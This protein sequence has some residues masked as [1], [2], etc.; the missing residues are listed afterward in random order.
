MQFGR[1]QSQKYIWTPTHQLHCF[2]GW[3]RSRRSRT[4]AGRRP[5]E[6]FP[7][8]LLLIQHKRTV[9]TRKVLTF[10]AEENARW[11]GAM[12]DST[13][14][15]FPFVTLLF[16][17]CCFRTNV[18]CPPQNKITTKTSG[19]I[20]GSTTTPSQCLLSVMLNKEMIQT[21][22]TPS[23]VVI[24]T[25]KFY[26]FTEIYLDVFLNNVLRPW[27]NVLSF[28]EGKKKWL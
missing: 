15:V 7:P 21:R 27:R 20:K 2:S 24:F 9:R 28:V 12:K 19:F 16:S 1:S 8:S 3:R 4:E 13:R 6:L 18:S 17:V 26:S 5:S 23:S 10:L 11:A 25:V 22:D 14:Q